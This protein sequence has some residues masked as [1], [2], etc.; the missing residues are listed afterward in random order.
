VQTDFL[1]A[2]ADLQAARA[3]LAR[4]RQAGIAVHIELARLL[5]TLDQAWIR[6]H[7]AWP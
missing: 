6:T 1:A 5:G 4:S 3:G 7:L 2:E